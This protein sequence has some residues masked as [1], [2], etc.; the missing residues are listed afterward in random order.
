MKLIK[1]TITNFKGIKHLEIEFSDETKIYG[2]NRTGKTSIKDAFTWVL[3]DK[4]SQDK[5]EFSVKPINSTGLTNKDLDVDVEV[6]FDNITLRKVLKENW[7]KPRGS[8]EAVLKGNTTECYVNGVPLKVTDYKKQVNDMIDESMFKLLTD[9]LYFNNELKWEQRRSMLIGLVGDI[10]LSEF[11]KTEAQQHIITELNKYSSIDAYKASINVLI[12]KTKKSIEELPGRVDEVNRQLPESEEDYAFAEQDAEA[13]KNKIAAVDQKISGNNSDELKSINRKIAEVNKGLND[14]RTKTSNEET[15]AKNAINKHTSALNESKL[16]HKSL[17]NALS[18]EAKKT[19]EIKPELEALRAKFNKVAAEKFS[20]NTEETCPTCGQ[21]LPSEQVEEAKKKAE[22]NWKIAQKEK[23]EDI[24]KEG[25]AKAAELSTLIKSMEAKVDEI[26]SLTE[27]VTKQEEELAKLRN[28]FIDAETTLELNEE[29][30]H[31]LSVIADLEAKL[32][33][34]SDVS[35][36]LAEKEITQKELD[37]AN[38]K[39]RERDNVIKLKS[40]LTELEKQEKELLAELTRLENIEFNISELTKAKVTAIEE[41]V[42]NNFKNVQYKMFETQLNGGEK[43]VCVA[44]VNGVPFPDVNTAGQI[45]AGI[46]AIN[47]FSERYGLTAPIFIDNA[48]AVV[49]FEP[50]KAQTIKLIVRENSP[51]ILE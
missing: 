5:K 12:K 51:L 38:K 8:E 49:S 31:G 40:R 48:E 20:N 11:A 30:Q 1:M 46:E 29:Y 23:L 22:T 10:Q 6:Q 27:Q 28:S 33:E 15:E 39:I 17:Q 42:N 4:N 50:T 21:N 41:K 18:S 3:F 9:P 47:V 14:I 44:T 2:D 32:T 45:N 35:E 7:Q 19:E 37:S 43:E 24:Q 26:K 25:K 13:A 36:L 16:K 34:T